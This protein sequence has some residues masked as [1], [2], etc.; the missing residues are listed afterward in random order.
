MSFIL[1]SA[2]ILHNIFFFL[3]FSPL[4][5][6]EKSAK[7]VELND[8]TA[9]DRINGLKAGCQYLEDFL[10]WLKISDFRYRQ[11]KKIKIN[12]I[13]KKTVRTIINRV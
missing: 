6:F 3:F 12:K 1:S 10:G 4:A 8:S 7:S 13:F 2:E 11:L 5:K 9:V